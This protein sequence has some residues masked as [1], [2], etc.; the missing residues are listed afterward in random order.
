MSSSN[1]SSGPN[2][3]IQSRSPTARN[4]RSGTCPIC[5]EELGGGETWSCLQCEALIHVQCMP[6]DLR[7]GRIHLENGCP[8]CRATMSDLLRTARQS[9]PAPNGAMCR[10]CW[11]PIAL[12][13]PMQCCA[14]PRRHCVATWH[15]E[16]APR[17]C[18]GCGLSAYRALVMRQWRPNA[19]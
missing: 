19:R 12:G 8:Q 3:R 17:Q 5:L 10:V 6:R 18:P 2:L 1:P 15:E 13:S 9:K 7:T 11:E 4:R 16:C 14:A